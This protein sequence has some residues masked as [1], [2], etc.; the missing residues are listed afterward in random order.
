MP[1]ASRPRRPW[2][3]FR[4]AHT[5]E[6]FGVLAVLVIVFAVAYYRRQVAAIPPP[7]RAISREEL[8]EQIA[9]KKR[10]EDQTPDPR[11]DTPCVPAQAP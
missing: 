8:D 9:E 6:L 2:H 3:E 5:L 10:L 1:D 7:G 11:E 4:L